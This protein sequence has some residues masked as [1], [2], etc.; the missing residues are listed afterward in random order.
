MASIAAGFNDDDDEELA[1]PEGDASAKMA[2]L[3]CWSSF[4]SDRCDVRN[5]CDTSSNV[6]LSIGCSSSTTPAPRLFSYD[7]AEAI[8]IAY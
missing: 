2:S 8:D 6:T 1:A 7:D 5:N 3:T 4:S